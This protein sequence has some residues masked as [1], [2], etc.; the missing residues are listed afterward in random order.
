MHLLRSFYVRLRAEGALSTWL[1]W[2]RY[3]KMQ[4]D[5]NLRLVAVL[6]HSSGAVTMLG[7]TARARDA[8][9]AVERHTPGMTRPCMGTTGL[10]KFTKKRGCPVPPNRRPRFHGGVAFLQLTMADNIQGFILET[11]AGE[12]P[13]ASSALFNLAA[14]SGESSDKRVVQSVNIINSGFRIKP[15]NIFAWSRTSVVSI[16]TVFEASNAD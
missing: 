7:T 2:L 8:A 5:G 3:S 15:A 10:P 1:V 6:E 13:R 11:L 16:T 12:M 4:I 14:S 9:I